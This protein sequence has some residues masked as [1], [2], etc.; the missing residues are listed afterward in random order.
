MSKINQI[1]G[2]K[3]VATLARVLSHEVMRNLKGVIDVCYEMWFDCVD[4]EDH[5][6]FDKMCLGA[7]D[8]NNIKLQCEGDLGAKLY[9]AVSHSLKSYS[10]VVVVGS[11]CPS[12]DPEYLKQA[13]ERLDETDAVLGPAEDGGYVLI[14]CKEVS[15]R[16]FDDVS[17]GT[18]FVLSKTLENLDRHGVSYSLL[19]KRWD[20]DEYDDYI[21]WTA[22]Q[23]E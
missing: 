4:N 2:N 23:T 13:F 21:R 22:S 9:G 20:V 5:G 19:E 12:V 10:K 17:W 8:V 11:D 18:E 1:D 6:A 14:G 3:F 16:F 15:M 7:S